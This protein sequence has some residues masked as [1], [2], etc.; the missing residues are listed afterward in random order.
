MWPTP[1]ISTRMSSYRL[2]RKHPYF[3]DP[4][5]LHAGNRMAATPFTQSLAEP[6]AHVL[7]IME[8][9][10]GGLQ[11]F[12]AA[13]STREFRI[14]M[15]ELHAITLVPRLVKRLA[16]LATNARLSP[17]QVGAENLGSCT[18]CSCR[19]LP[20]SW[21]ACPRPF[22]PSP[23]HS[24][25]TRAL[26]AIVG[27][28]FART[29][30]RRGQG[31]HHLNPAGFHCARSYLTVNKFTIVFR[32]QRFPGSA[33]KRRLQCSETVKSRRGNGGSMML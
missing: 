19:L 2:E 7:R 15:N 20:S 1:S 30:L 29:G 21:C 10:I 5:F 23:S 26:Q 17:I 22:R 18:S 28:V 12:D 11:N 24:I 25:G 32:N 16:Q 8:T 27:E 14:D 31:C 13:S 3:S 6:A 33:S 4:L 9:K